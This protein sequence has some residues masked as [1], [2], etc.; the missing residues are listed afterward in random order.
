MR[1]GYWYLNREPTKAEIIMWGL[2][3]I[4]AQKN[5]PEH[6]HEQPWLL[7]AAETK[8]LARLVRKRGRRAI[9]A[10]TTVVP[11][12]LRGRRSRGS[13]PAVTKPLTRPDTKA[14]AWLVGKYGRDVIRSLTTKVRL[15][16]R[17]RPTRGDLPYYERIHFADWLEEVADEHR[18]AGSRKP[19]VD[20]AI[21]LY[22]MEFEGEQNRPDLHKFLSTVKRK[23]LQGRRELHAMREAAQRREQWLQAKKCRAK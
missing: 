8:A 21:D 6:T 3:R 4:A 1:R 5:Q 19:Y 13:L 23:R 15:P 7:T 20:S 2:A 9:I 11:L 16:G 10:A 22:E 18:R 17:G 12:P 14:L